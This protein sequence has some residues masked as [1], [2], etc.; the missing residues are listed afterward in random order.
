MFLITGI[1]SMS[2]GEEAL[3][4]KDE[5]RPLHGFMGDAGD[6]VEQRPV[7]DVIE[8][9]TGYER[10]WRNLGLEKSLGEI[11]FTKEFGVIST[12]RGS[13]VSFRLRDEGDGKLKVMAIST[14]DIRP[15]LRYAIGVLSRA[16]WKQVNDTKL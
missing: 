11:D 7:L 15:G 1:L 16:E 3:K 9:Q 8:D 2:F 5:P 14:R 13:R 12:T 4:M 10:I 6:G